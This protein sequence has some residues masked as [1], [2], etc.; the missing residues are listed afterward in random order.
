MH[1]QRIPGRRVALAGLAGAL[2]LSAGIAATGG[3]TPQRRRPARAQSPMTPPSVTALINRYLAAK[4]SASPD[5]T[6]AFFDQA[7]TTYADATLGWKFP[8]WDSLKAL[9]DQYMPQ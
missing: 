4:S 8:T 5:R 3:P 2:A 1:K 6:M 9:F 7:S